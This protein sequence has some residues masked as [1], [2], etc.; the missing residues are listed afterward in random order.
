[1]VTGKSDS[2]GGGYFDEWGCLLSL[3][4]WNKSGDFCMF[5]PRGGSSNGLWQCGLYSM[6]DVSSQ[7][8]HQYR[9][10]VMRINSAPEP[11]PRTRFH[12]SQIHLPQLRDLPPH[13]THLSIRSSDLTT[14]SPSP[15]GHDVGHPSDDAAKQCLMPRS[16]PPQHIANTTLPRLLQDIQQVRSSPC[17]PSSSSRPT[18]LHRRVRLSE[19]VSTVIETPSTNT[20]NGDES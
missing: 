12:D 15:P 20:W 11:R 3:W 1:M 7:H 4:Q 6:A 13:Y 16:T 19:E 9:S 8:T 18:T 14:Y 17:K 5:G 2:D 10:T